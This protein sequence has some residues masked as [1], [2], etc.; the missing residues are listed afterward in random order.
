LIDRGVFSASE[1]LEKLKENQGDMVD[2]LQ[3]AA[4]EFKGEDP[5]S[6]ADLD[7]FMN[8]FNQH[9]EGYFKKF[10]E[11]NNTQTDIDSEPGTSI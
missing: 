11:K 9:F 3:S 10:D 6:L 2:T 5:K 1:F 8:A 7:R 4:K